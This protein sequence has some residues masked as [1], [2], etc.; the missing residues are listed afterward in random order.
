MKVNTLFLIVD[1]ENSENI[2]NEFKSLSFILQTINENETEDIVV[3]ESIVEGYKKDFKEERYDC[4]F[5]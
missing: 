3:L 5:L 2:T 1:K 4:S